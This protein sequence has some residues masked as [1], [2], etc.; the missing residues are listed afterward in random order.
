L[1]QS[2]YSKLYNPQEIGDIRVVD[3]FD[4]D[5][6]AERWTK[7]IHQGFGSSWA[8]S[9]VIDGGFEAITDTNQAR[10]ELNFGGKHQYNFLGAKA[11]GI[12][13]LDTAQSTVAIGLDSL[14]FT[15]VQTLNAEGSNIDTF[16]RLLTRFAV[17]TVTNTSIATDSVFHRFEPELTATTARLL[18]DGIL[19]ATHTT[20]LPQVKLQPFLGAANAFG[21][22]GSVTVAYRYYEAYNT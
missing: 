17:P 12:M 10:I 11:I 9:D 18:L 16:F 5:D 20:N 15:G 14:N 3:R 1:V 7:V 13:K 8:M 22:G 4:G 21:G 6:L 19:E 2:L